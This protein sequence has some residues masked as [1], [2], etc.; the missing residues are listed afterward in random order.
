MRE[1][2]TVFIPSPHFPPS[3]MPPSQR[4]RLLIRHLHEFGWRP[5]IFTVDHYY[6]EEAADPWMLEIAGNAFEK[7]E[8]SAW[9]QRKTR[10]FGVGDLGIRM[11]SGLY[12]AML[13][14]AKKDKPALILY[15][16]PPWYI[17]IMAPWIKRATGIPYAIDFIDPWVYNT[18]RKNIK[19]VLSQ[20]VARKLE[21]RIVKKSDAIFAVSQGI[22]EDLKK[23]YPSLPPIPMVA[24][25]YGVEVSDYAAIRVQ[26]K[27]G[28]DIVIRYTGAVSEKMLA[29]I[30]SLLAAFK[31][32]NETLPVKVIFT[33]T[34][35]AGLGLV[36]PV[37]SELIARNGVENFVTEHPARVS[38]REALEINRQA[39]MQLL[40]G[41]TTPY[42]A[43]SK[44]MGLIASGKPFFAWVHADS[45]PAKFLGELQYPHYLS[46][47]T[48]E[49]GST[50][51][52][53][54]L[55]AAL[56]N[57][58]QQRDR[59]VPVSL[60]HPVFLKHTAKA[61]TKIFADTFQKI[62]DEEH[63]LR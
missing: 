63:T 42:Y 37:L 53:E 56:L 61:M 3:A 40:I 33:G 12:R 44:M 11:F 57:S 25:P 15:P 48:E 41:D 4:V 39:D 9:D 17:M 43:A 7:I 54:Q 32:L 22:L 2:K 47:T 30:D 55:S 24:V 31:K 16:V 29:V 14:Q 20:W 10:K 36:K 62:S 19:A 49:L 60:E 26:Q 27:D 21:G 6:R 5:V 38:Y 1:K 52:T 23:R 34:S 51:K 46:F 50:G 13:R 58:L 59:F 45:F 28:Q 18:S 35:Y 8:V